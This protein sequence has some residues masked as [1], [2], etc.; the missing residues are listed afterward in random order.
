[1][2][3]KLI[4]V[5]KKMVLENPQIDLLIPTGT[6]F[7]LVIFSLTSS[8]LITSGNVGIKEDTV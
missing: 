3:Q 8:I 5:T 6:L 1:M 7:K 2:R 4:E